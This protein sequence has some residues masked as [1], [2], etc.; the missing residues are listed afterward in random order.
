MK[1]TRRASGKNFVYL[2]KNKDRLK[3]PETID[4]IKSLVIPPAW[5]DVEITTNKRAKI[6]AYGRDQKGRKQ[7]IY[8]PRFRARKDADKFDRILHFAENLEHMR[9]VTGQHLRKKK[10]SREKVL[11]AM[12][13]LLDSAYFRPGSPKYTQQNKS[14]GLTTIRKKH[15]TIE[16]DE[17]IFSYKGKSGKFQEKHVINSKLSKV[18]KQLEALPGYRLFKYYDENDALI[19]VESQDLNQYIKEVMGEEFSAKDF[20]TWAGTMIAAGI[21]DELGICEKKQQKELKI[22]V[23]NAIVAVS[24]K[25]GNT[26]SVA[27]DSYIDPRIFEHYKNGHTIHYFQKEIKKLLKKNENLSETEVGVLYMLKSKLKTSKS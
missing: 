23:R 3:D 12:V 16:G 20:R 21:L 4:Y 7:Y 8:N 24:E 9:R 5:K 10:M 19:F 17:M 25:L 15:L 6:L 13:R 26:P 2:D 27:R 22:R 11:A 1:I 18:I 14:Y